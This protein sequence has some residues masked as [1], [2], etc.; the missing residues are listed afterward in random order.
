MAEPSFASVVRFKFSLTRALHD[1]KHERS[2]DAQVIHFWDTHSLIMPAR[3]AAALPRPGANEAQLANSLVEALFA[4]GMLGQVAMLRPHRAEFL[5]VVAEWEG[6]PRADEQLRS[7]GLVNLTSEDSVAEVLSISN[8]LGD[9][10]GSSSADL[11]EAARRLTQLDRNGFIYVQASAGGWQQRLRQLTASRLLSLEPYGEPVSYLHNTPEFSLVVDALAERRTRMPFSNMVDAAAIASLIQLREQADRG[12]SRI[13]ARFFTSAQSLIRLYAELPWLRRALSFPSDPDTPLAAATVWRDHAY[14]FVRALFPVLRR[15][16][17][18]SHA[19]LFGTPS[20]DELTHLESELELALRSDDLGR[21][22]QREVLEGPGGN[23]G[24]LIESFQQNRMPRLWS[25]YE[26]SGLPLDLATAMS[27]L[28]RL[29]GEEALLEELERKGGTGM[30]L[31]LHE[32]GFTRRVIDV[33]A[34]AVAHLSQGREDVAMSISE[35][36]SGPRWGVEYRNGDDDDI[37]RGPAGSGPRAYAKLFADFSIDDL[38]KPNGQL[39]RSVAIL[40]GLERFDHAAELLRLVEPQPTPH[41]RVLGHIARLGERSIWSEAD[42]ERTVDD[43]RASWDATLKTPDAARLALPHAWAVFLAWQRS[44]RGGAWASSAPRDDLD[45]ARSSIEIVQSMRNQMSHL[46]EINAVNHIVYV[47]ASSGVLVDDYERLRVDLESLADL[48]GDFHFLDTVGFALLSEADRGLESGDIDPA[49]ARRMYVRAI[50]RFDE[51]L[52]IFP[53][54]AEISN[55][56]RLA[57][58]A[59]L[60]LGSTSPSSG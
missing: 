28:H 51:A 34:D 1:V 2:H 37:V 31:E 42:L 11:K 8:L 56:R 41:L 12:E 33:V 48:R 60:D 46:G 6:D 30:Y 47:S 3:G 7:R 57:V 21:L 38:R 16:L 13:F 35:E 14:Y 58:T 19:D 36:L 43:I 44:A 52:G 4:A 9:R 49:E 54:D 25:N 50:D 39:V 53:D 15:P 29:S 27:N 24:D 45:W 10:G 40:L 18:D 5:G 26:G 17:D 32:A 20:L 23:L 22:L 59:M 55:H